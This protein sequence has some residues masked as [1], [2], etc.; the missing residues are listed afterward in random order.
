[1]RREVSRDENGPTVALF[2]AKTDIASRSGIHA[3]VFMGIHAAAEEVGCSLLVHYLAVKSATGAKVRS[4]CRHADG[5]IMV[6]EY[7][8]ALHDLSLPIPAVGVGMHRPV[9]PG[10]SLIDIDPFSAAELATAH[11]ERHGVRRVVIVTSDMDMLS[12][13]NRCA[14]FSTSWTG[15]GGEIGG[16]LHDSDFQ[17]VEQGTGYLFATSSILQHCSARS[18]EKTGRTLAE[19][20]VVL[21]IDGKNLTEPTYHAA[22]AVATDWR[23]VGAGAL[24]ECLRRIG[25][26]GRPPRRIY[27]QGRLV[28]PQEAGRGSASKAAHAALQV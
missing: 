5:M 2:V 23:A 9:C 1:M 21:G 28:E 22:A 14:V 16:V 4:L 15:R 24:E 11:F 12:L 26:P 10:M 18:L 7:D 25:E 17:G 8:A 6:A 20:A 27:F 13:R 19:Q 3:T